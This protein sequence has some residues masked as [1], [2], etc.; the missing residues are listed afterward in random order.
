MKRR[1]NLETYDFHERCDRA[2]A[3]VLAVVGLA[4]LV[5]TG[6]TGPL[7][8]GLVELAYAARE[9]MGGG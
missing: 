3:V 6:A 5:F 2:V 8:A 9:A 7:W 4:V 1:K